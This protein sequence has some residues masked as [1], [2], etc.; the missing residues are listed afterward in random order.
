[1]QAPIAVPVTVGGT[2]LPITA[3]AWPSARGEGNLG[4]RGL[5]GMRLSVDH[6]HGRVAIEPSGEAPT[7]G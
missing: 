4:S 1:M 6:A 3:I 2:P 5:V 7:C